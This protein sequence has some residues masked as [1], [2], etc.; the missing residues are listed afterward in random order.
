M[1]RV[2]KA[3][4]ENILGTVIF[5]QHWL[6]AALPQQHFPVR[7]CE[8]LPFSVEFLMKFFDKIFRIF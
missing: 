7:F 5:T 6:N 3:L 2:S 8:R 1:K 4:H